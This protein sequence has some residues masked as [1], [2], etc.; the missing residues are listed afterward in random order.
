[1][2]WW[3]GKRRCSASSLSD[4]LFGACEVMVLSRKSV[5][6]KQQVLQLVVF[7]DAVAA[8]DAQT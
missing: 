5:M 7:G 2:I 8:E 4:A 3:A 6:V 1:M